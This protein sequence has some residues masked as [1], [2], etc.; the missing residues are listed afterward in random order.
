LT[1]SSQYSAISRKLI[2]KDHSGI[3][4]QLEIADWENAKHSITI[5]FFLFEQ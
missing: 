1:A 5:E 4:K 2:K 3:T